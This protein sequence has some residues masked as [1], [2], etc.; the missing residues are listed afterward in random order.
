MRTFQKLIGQQ[1]GKVAE[2]VYATDLKSVAARL[3]GSSPSLPT[4][5]KYDGVMSESKLFFDRVERGAKNLDRVAAFVSKVLRRDTELG[6]GRRRRL[7]LPAA[8]TDTNSALPFTMYTGEMPSLEK[9]LDASERL[10]SGKSTSF[11]EHIRQSKA[12][13]AFGLSPAAEM[14]EGTA[15][16]YGF[17]QGPVGPMDDILDASS[18]MRGARPRSKPEQPP[19]K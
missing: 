9:A 1:K 15:L 18:R 2:L 13:I 3:E 19:E 6:F 10:R 12:D 4:K 8:A 17:C 5:P 7:W 16:P 11:T 14:E